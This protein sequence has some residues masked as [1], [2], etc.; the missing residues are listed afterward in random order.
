MPTAMPNPPPDQHKAGG[1]GE[2]PVEMGKMSLS[3]QGPRSWKSPG[4]GPVPL[5]PGHLS[6]TPL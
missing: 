2:S 5:L 4:F 3:L 1:S 6:E